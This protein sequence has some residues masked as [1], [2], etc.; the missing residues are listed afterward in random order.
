VDLGGYRMACVS[1]AD[2]DEH[3]TM[4][5]VAC[6]G[7]E[8]GYFKKVAVTWADAPRGRGPTGTAVRTGKAAIVRN[9]P[10]DPAFEPW[11]KEALKRGYLSTIA[12]PLT[13]EGR[14]FGILALYADVI[15]A[16]GPGEVEVLEEL[17]ADLAFGLTVV[18]RTRAERRTAIE[19]LKT[20][21]Q[22]LA[23]AQRVAHVGHW[24]R[25][26]KTDLIECSDELFR[27]Y[28]LTP[29][30][31]G[32]PLSYFTRMIHP[33]DRH[34][35]D[36]AR[37]EALRRGGPSDAEFR[38][39]RPDHQVRF[40]HCDWHVKRNDAGRPLRTFG[41]IQDITERH[42]ARQAMEDA[43][44][45]LEAKNI[46]LREVL[47]NI[48]A[49]QR[50]LGRRIVTNMQKI[51]L[52]LVHSLK[53]GLPLQQQRRLEHIEHAMEDVVSPFI[54]DVSRAVETLTPAELRI[55]NFVRRGLAV[56][57]IAELEHL[58]PQTVAAH[59]RSI[60]R[61]LGIANRKVNLT[62]YLQHLFNKSLS[63]KG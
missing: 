16:F 49:E 27:I 8:A 23:E 62:A 33:E 40:V 42:L 2:Q 35:V 56:K 10:H 59:R 36:Q 31:D 60:R 51:V 39:I 45:A 41:I 34:R 15:D 6:A 53:Q 20:S 5:M 12:L 37:K 22:R 58:S 44:R 25:D 21:E 38:I 18:L 57:E 43:N 11:R 32:V 50:K 17:A 1:F 55:V 4:R 24:E 9:I 63:Q 52:P 61:K 30:P 47:G 13:S 54:D 28:G 3:K 26:L 46:A 19:A 14:T 48:E 29:R 7:F